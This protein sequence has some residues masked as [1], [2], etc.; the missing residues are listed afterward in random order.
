MIKHKLMFK[1]LLKKTNMRY[2]ISILEIL[3]FGVCAFSFANITYAGNASFYLSPESGV[4]TIGDEFP[5]SIMLDTDSEPIVAAEGN[6]KFNKEEL[7]IVSLSKDGSILTQWTIEPEYLSEEGEVR[8][9]GALPSGEEY[10]GSDGKILTITFKAMRNIASNVRFSTGAAI[11]AADSS[12]TNILTRMNSGVYTLNAK[13]VV[14]TVEYVAQANT[15]TSTILCTTHPDQDAWYSN[16]IPEFSWTLPEGTESVRVLFSEE[17]SAIPTIF[18]S[19]PITE[20]TIEEVEDGVGY[21]H[22]QVKNDT[23]W[24]EV[25]SHKVQIDTVDPENFEIVEILREDTTNPDLSFV[26]NAFDALS[27]IDGFEVSLDGSVGEIWRPEISSSTDVVYYIEDVDPGNHTLV[28]KAIDRAGNNISQT[29]SFVVEA[30]EI[31]K[32]THAPESLIV[33]SM[34]AVKGTTYPDS[35]VIVWIEKDE[36]APKSTR[37]LS[38][39]SGDFIYVLEESVKEGVYNVWVQAKNIYGAQS[40]PSAK[41]SI[42]VERIGIV[43]FGSVALDYL[44]VLVPLI[45]LVVLL[46]IFLGYGWNKFR[47]Y[48]RRLRKEVIEAEDVL[49]SQFIE[50][51]AIIHNELSVLERVRE[52]RA[53]TP[54]EERM[55]RRLG[56]GMSEVESTVGK[57]FE[58]IKQMAVDQDEDIEDHKERSVQQAN[59]V[60]VTEEKKITKPP[61]YKSK[62]KGNSQHGKMQIRIEK[63]H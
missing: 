52:Q 33:E 1:D 45:G 35:E 44:S 57:E 48:R 28:A 59:Q 41:I 3:I 14:P 25:L 2:L 63:L 24:G 8:F 19:T 6:V 49:H 9:G 47:V 7:E 50:L 27:G 54:E 56:R 34:L 40:E 23:G 36:E 37:I 30:L 4:Y 39:S 16:S 15:V 26:F 22:L 38:D 58:D 51:R 43:V 13:E 10:K 53:L 17:K 29:V 55:L 5:V 61:V 20:K 42:P 12:A 11:L 31:P 60:A 18:Y 46:F 21:F 62:E 32:I